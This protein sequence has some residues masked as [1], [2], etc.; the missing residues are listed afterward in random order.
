MRLAHITDLHVEHT[1][2]VGE[3][4]GKRLFGAVNL[5]LLGRS[6]HFSCDVQAALP[7]AVLATRPDRIVCTGD[8]TATATDAEFAAAKALL[9]PLLSV[10]FDCIAGNHDVYTAESLGRY[11]RY[12]GPDLAGGA[13][14]VPAGPV[15]LVLF[16][17]CEPAWLSRGR[18]TP[19][20]LT[21]L[22]AA[23]ASSG[24]CILCLHYPLR[25]RGGEPYGPPTRALSNAAAVEEIIAQH[26]NVVTVLH[27]HE[28]HGYTTQLP[29]VA[30]RPGV[31]IYNPGS[32][33]Y[34]CMPKKH[35]TAH[36]NVYDVE[37]TGIVAVE[38]YAW[39]GTSF[40][41]EPGGA[42]ATGG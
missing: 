16:D 26:P 7:A 29:A 34:A 19:S 14:R 9:A 6:H 2:R 38:R 5:Y 11:G 31:S 36:F 37:P 20:G 35:R 3:L 25:G 13:L 28:H 40:E 4:V 33:G 21:A 41:P 8:L 23:L 12:F 15:D 17:V 39:T 30:G 1:P 24:P 42:Y 10:P 32:S 27:G 22:D 18:A